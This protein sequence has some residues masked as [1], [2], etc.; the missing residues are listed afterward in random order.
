MADEVVHEPDDDSQCAIVARM[1]AEDVLVVARRRAGLSQRDL[2]ARLGR[3]QSTIGRWETG[4]RSPSFDDVVEALHACDLELGPDLFARDDSLLAD[5]RSRL[6]L[7]PVERLTRLGGADV[8]EPLELV[9]ASG[10]RTVVVG[11]VAGAM[12]GW[13]LRLPDP[14]LELVAAEL[15][16]DALREQ[17]A[18]AGARPEPVPERRPRSQAGRVE[19]L[20][21]ASGA[22]V[23]LLSD[24]AGTRG[25]RDLHA[26]VDGLVIGDARVAVAGVRDLIRIADASHATGGR[27][28]LPALYAVLAARRLGPHRTLAHDSPQGRAA[29]D[30]WLTAQAS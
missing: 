5:A 14:V 12:Q 24:V 15:D 3:P 9:A 6:E 2:A 16:H 7:T 28:V 1:V 22:A 19:R 29:L 17:L 4:A 30:A 18:S 13:P 27:Y 21:L 10:Q 11:E 26:D 8:Q 20:Q 23:E 25:Y